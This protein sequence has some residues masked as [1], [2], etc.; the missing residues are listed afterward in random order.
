MLAGCGHVSAADCCIVQTLM[1]AFSRRM[2][3]AITAA[4]QSAVSSV[5]AMKVTPSST[6]SSVQVTYSSPLSDDLLPFIRNKRVTHEPTLTADTGVCSLP[7]CLWKDVNQ[8]R[9]SVVITF[10]VSRRRREM[11]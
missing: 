6:A 11:Y 3:R 4:T 10:R 7:V 1:S 9:I 8:E 2:T 5:L